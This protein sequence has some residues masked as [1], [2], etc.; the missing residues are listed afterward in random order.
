MY[1]RVTMETF[2]QVLRMY[3]V[4]SKLLNGIK[5][6]Y[7]NRVTCIRVKEGLEQAFQD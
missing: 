3:D 7:V 4:I 6:M 5:S 1:E 2:C